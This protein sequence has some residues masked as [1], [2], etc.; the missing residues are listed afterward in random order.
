[1]LSIGRLSKKRMRKVGLPPGTPVFVGE[2]KV[3][4][5]K[6]SVIDY[7]DEQI[8]EQELTDIEECFPLKDTPTVSWINVD[9]VHDVDIAKKI[10]ANF[11]IH[12]LVLEDIVNTEHRPK[13]EDYG[14]YVYIVLKMLSVKQ[15]TKE[16]EVE[17]VSL[18]LGAYFVITF[19]EREGDIF[20]FI[21]E[22]IKNHKGRIRRMGTDYLAY[23]LIDAV[24]DNYFNI[25]DKI[26]EEIER[27]EE[28][29]LANP[30]PELLQNLHRLKQDMLFLK[31]SV[32]PLR[33]IVNS[34]V[35][36][37]SSLVHETSQIY[38]RDVYDH[39]IHVIDSIETMRDM[40]SGMLDTYLSSIS[41]RMNEVMKVLTII[42]TI[43]I[44]LTFLAGI[45]GMNFKF[46]PE[47]EWKWG[48]FT[49]WS[50]MIIVFFVMVF[51]FR[52]KKWF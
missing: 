45:Y 26:S 19:Q 2:K 36:G 8:T 7:D 12:P 23:S 16:I 41:N 38:F 29:L 49:I 28:N 21:R 11:G 44:P 1:M 9:G 40:I 3:E 34:L 24:V 5:M 13:I 48:Y 15:E 50:V 33:E 27:L 18:I 52:R 32:G 25:L 22:R 6:I 17:Q 4:K 43:F 10:G 20:N 47:L 30:Q 35:R 14:E 31:K 37:D 42:A 51:Y 46:M 39:T